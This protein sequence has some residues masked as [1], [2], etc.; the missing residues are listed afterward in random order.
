MLIHSPGSADA[1]WQ[2]YDSSGYPTQLLLL[3]LEYNCFDTP[4]FALH[5][6]PPGSYNIHSGQHLFFIMKE[7]RFGDG[8]LGG[9]DKLC[10]CLFRRSILVS[11]SV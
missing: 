6:S 2:L 4:P 5:A 10:T 1:H 9:I 3:R 11:L 7:G 8:Y